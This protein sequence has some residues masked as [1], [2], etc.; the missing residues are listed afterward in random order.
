MRIRASA[1]RRAIWS[2][3]V[4]GVTLSASLPAD[5]QSALSLG[6]GFGRF[7]G[8]DF[9]GTP[10]GPTVGGAY[11]L[12]F[13]EY[14][15]EL[16]FG[17]DYS[18]YG[19]HGFVGPTRQLDYSAVIRKNVAMRPVVLAGLRIGYSTRALS[20]V[21]EPAR[22]DGFLI[23]PTFSLRVPTGLALLLDLSLDGLYHAY[24][25]LILY[26]TREYGTD[27]DGFRILLRLG[28][29]MPLGGGGGRD[30]GGAF[31]GG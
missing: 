7:A 30:E 19:E 8:A 28:V 20:V 1:A 4:A 2:L 13:E 5:A 29:L 6:G 23:G 27:Q 18:R 12:A 15:A 11:H 3:G 25:E 17:V 31:G 16:S 10:G 14:A 9:S 24:E 22:T 21:D 26:A